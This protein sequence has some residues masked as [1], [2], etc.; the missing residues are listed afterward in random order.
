[1]GFIPMVALYWFENRLL[2]YWFMSDVFPTLIV[3]ASPRFG[4]NGRVAEAQLGEVG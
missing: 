4:V 2:T 1:M 3:S